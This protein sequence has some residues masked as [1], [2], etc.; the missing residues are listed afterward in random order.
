[1]IKKKWSG[2]KWKSTC[3]VSWLGKFLPEIKSQ[4]LQISFQ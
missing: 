1:M 3:S 4:N 2:T